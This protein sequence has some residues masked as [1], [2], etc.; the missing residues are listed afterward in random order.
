MASW[1]RFI[2]S[3]TLLAL[4][5]AAKE[6]ALFTAVA[7]TENENELAKIP[8]V[9]VMGNFQLASLAIGDDFTTTACAAIEQQFNG[10][11]TCSCTLSRL[12]ESTVTYACQR[13]HHTCKKGVCAQQ[14][15]TGTVGLTS[16]HLTTDICS[17]GLSINGETV[18]DLCVFM[19][20]TKC[21]ATLNKTPCGCT[22]CNTKGGLGV[23]VDCSS[24]HSNAVSSS[25]DVVNVVTGIQNGKAGW[26]ADVL[27][28]FN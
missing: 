1:R 23:Q 2:L 10:P 15:H 25:C 14:V 18:G 19:E 20:S 17:T 24:V 7:S 26:L 16:R 4:S 8:S 27:P 13:A 6:R 12:L 3:A 22:V 21:M 11:V 5:V 28:S 9:R